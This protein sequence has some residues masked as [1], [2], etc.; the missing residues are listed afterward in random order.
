MSA[1][2]PRILFFGTCWPINMGNAFVNYGAIHALQKACGER[3]TVEHFGGLSSY[4]F[5]IR[6]VGHFSF[7]LG[8]WVDYDYVVMAG[9]TQCPDHFEAAEKNLRTYLDRGAKIIIAGGAGRN[10]DPAEGRHR[11]RVDEAPAGGNLHLA[12]FLFV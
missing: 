8:E 9:M 1:T 5:S 4:M 12:R 10:Y 3:A 7:A 11:A 6:G 2:H